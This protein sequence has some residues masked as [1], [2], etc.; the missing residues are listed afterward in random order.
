MII[1][2]KYLIYYQ[3][4][5]EFLEKKLIEIIKKHSADLREA[6]FAGLAGTL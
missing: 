5:K 6:P 4:S 2:A 1:S 3:D